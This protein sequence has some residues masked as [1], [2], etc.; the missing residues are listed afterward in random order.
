MSDPTFI[1]RPDGPPA[2]AD[3]PQGTPRQCDHCGRTV[4]DWVV[5][6]RADDHGPLQL[7]WCTDSRACDDAKR[8]ADRRPPIWLTAAR[9]P[10]P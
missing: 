7:V 6:Q 4:T 9:R 10:T 3:I 8:T 5:R 2:P 1:G